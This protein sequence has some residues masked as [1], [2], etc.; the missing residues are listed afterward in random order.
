ML[1]KLALPPHPHPASSMQQPAPY[2]SSNPPPRP[3]RSPREV[4]YTPHHHP[5]QAVPTHLHLLD[6][7]PAA[8]GATAPLSDSVESPTGSLASSIEI[9]SSSSSVVTATTPKPGVAYPRFPRL[10]EYFIVVGAKQP[11]ALLGT[12]PPLH[13]CYLFLFLFLFYFIIK[14]YSTSDGLCY[15][16][17]MIY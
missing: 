16:N 11:L 7:E 1:N 5:H 15:F 9:A 6:S 8:G 13:I 4:T 12:P 3:P 10:A 17:V 2:S 14:L